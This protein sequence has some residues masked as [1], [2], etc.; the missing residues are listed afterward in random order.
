LGSLISIDA[1]K[2]MLAINLIEFTTEKLMS[3]Q[4]I[5][6]PIRTLEGVHGVHVVPHSP[7]ALEKTTEDGD[8]PQSISRSSAIEANQRLLMQ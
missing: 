4:A 1:S 8:F 6:N 2:F 7:F 3:P 5:L